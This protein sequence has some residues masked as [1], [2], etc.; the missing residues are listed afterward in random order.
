MECYVKNKRIRYNIS[1][2]MKKLRRHTVGGTKQ[3]IENIQWK[4]IDYFF[5]LYKHPLI[6]IK[7]RITSRKTKSFCLLIPEFNSDLP[8]IL[9]P[10][11]L[12]LKRKCFR[13]NIENIC[14]SASEP[15]TPFWRSFLKDIR[16]DIKSWWSSLNDNRHVGAEFLQS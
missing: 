4:Q 1:T 14:S 9:P 7:N 13:K 3:I 5:F 11:I 15:L 2:D 10:R 16:V 12:F 8:E 6:A